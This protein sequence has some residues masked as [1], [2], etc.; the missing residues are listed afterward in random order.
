M[1][2]VLTSLKIGGAAAAR[3]TLPRRGLTIRRGV[4]AILVALAAG[5]I[6]AKAGDVAEL[7]RGARFVGAAVAGA[8]LPL[9]AESRSGSAAV[10]VFKT[11]TLTD[12]RVSTPRGAEHHH[13]HSE[14]TKS[15]HGEG[16]KALLVAMV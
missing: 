2:D 3:E 14:E 13:R 7:S 11:I 8:S 4:E 10:F 12:A 5:A 15:F 16:V 1:P 9:A 6:L